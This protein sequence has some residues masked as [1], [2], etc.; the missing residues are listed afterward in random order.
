MPLHSILKFRNKPTIRATSLLSNF[1]SR[2]KMS[3]LRTHELRFWLRAQKILP[4]L[5]LAPSARREN[6]GRGK[7]WSGVKCCVSGVL[8]ISYLI[9]R[10]YCRGSMQAHSDMQIG[11]A[12][13]KGMLASAVSTTLK[14]RCKML[15]LLLLRNP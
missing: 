14:K 10:V 6:S 9:Y 12:C 1:V 2:K 5:D 8:F 4:S 7:F 3:R 11:A 13:R 15:F